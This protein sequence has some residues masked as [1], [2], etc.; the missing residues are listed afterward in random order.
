[1][2][3]GTD[4]SSRGHG[5]RPS[6]VL[7]ADLG[8]ARNTVAHAYAQLVAEGWLEAHR[9]RDT[10]VAHGISGSPLSQPE[11]AAEPRPRYDLRPGVPDVGVRPHMSLG[12]RPDV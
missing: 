11:P 8:L 9:G 4:V 12:M 3:S 1:M 5:C 7:A 2:R 6:R 10:S